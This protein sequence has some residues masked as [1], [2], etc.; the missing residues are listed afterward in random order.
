MTMA[1]TTA[2]PA[3][4]AEPAQSSAPSTVVTAEAARALESRDPATGEVIATF[5]VDGEAEVRE[6][7]D[8]AR[9]AAQWWSGLGFAARQRRLL[10]WARQLTEHSDE[11]ADLVRAENG[12]PREDAYLELVMAL[13]HLRWAAKHARK[14]LASRRVWPGPFM[15]NF[16]ATVEYRPFGVVGVIGPWNYP[17]YTPFGSIAYALAAGNTVVFKPSEYTTAIGRYL[18]D[19]FAAANPDAPGGVLGLVTGYGATGAALCRSAV[20]KIAFTGSPGTGRKIMA[21]CAETLKP[22]LMECGGKD[23]MIVADD[24]AVPA[25]AEAAAWGALQNSGQA[26]VGIERIYVTE[27]VRDRFLAELRKAL[28]GVRPGDDDG[29]TYGPMTMPAQIDIVRRHI[30]AA[31]DAGGT[32][33]VGGPDS[34]REPFIEPV[35][36]VDAPED[37]AAVREETFGPTLTVR[38]VGNVDEAVRLANATNYGLGSAVFSRRRGVDIA[39]RIDSGAT[40]VNSVIAYAVIPGLP[41]GG[42]GDSGFGRIHGLEGLREFARPKAIARRRY[43]IPGTDLMTFRRN[44]IMLAVVKR[45]VRLRH[46]RLRG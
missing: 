41:F 18:V 2:T 25:A 45:L 38:T 23:A 9:S 13:E 39:R 42:S 40:S 29:A 7:V 34:V 22:V 31:L 20:D 37:C 10:G 30:A 14:A 8:Q 5:P 17:I 24:A 33:L 3:D 44:R 15:A 46:G 4:T 19:A 21:A 36:I 32:A 12:K 1:K 27:A 16:A 28:D 11:L 26:C 43:A 35:V 6:A